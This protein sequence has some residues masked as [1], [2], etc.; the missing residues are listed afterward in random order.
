MK[1]IDWGTVLLW[2][3]VILM[4]IIVVALIVAEIKAAIAII[5]SDSI[6]FWMKWVLL[7]R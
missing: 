6:P 7:T 5:T 4:A 2:L 1:K 3:F